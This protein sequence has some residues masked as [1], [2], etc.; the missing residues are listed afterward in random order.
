[1]NS[2]NR[3]STSIVPPCCWVTMSQAIDKPSPVPSPV[4]FVVTKGWNTPS[5]QLPCLSPVSPLEELLQVG[6]VEEAVGIARFSVIA[7]GVQTLAPA[8]PKIRSSG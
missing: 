8:Y 1:M 3:L 6:I 7:E 4:G 2:P 5:R